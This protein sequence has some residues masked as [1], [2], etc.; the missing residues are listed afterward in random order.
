LGQDGNK[1]ANKQTYRHA[2]V[3]SADERADRRVG[4]ELTD[5][6][7]DIRAGVELK[8]SGQTGTRASTDERMDDRL[9]VARK[10]QN[11]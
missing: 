4:D 10:P 6:Q 5:K 9:H 1:S 8:M 7:T 2:G 3:E 11:S